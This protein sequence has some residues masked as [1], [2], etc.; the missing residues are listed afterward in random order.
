V[1][2]TIQNITLASVLV[3]ALIGPVLAKIAFGKAK[4]IREE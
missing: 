2:A 3:F 4:E 1:G